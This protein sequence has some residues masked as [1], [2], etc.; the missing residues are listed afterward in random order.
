MMADV[1]RNLCTFLKRFSSWVALIATG[2]AAWWLNQPVDV[3]QQFLAAYPLLKSLGPSAT[4]LAYVVAK[5][6]PQGIDKPKDAGD[7]T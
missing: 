2:V 3:Q 4:L 6:L 1:K 7:G 5:V